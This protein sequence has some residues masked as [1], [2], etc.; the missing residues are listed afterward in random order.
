MEDMK[1]GNVLIRKKLYYDDDDDIKGNE[2]RL[3]DKLSCFVF[4]YMLTVILGSAGMC[5]NHSF[6]PLSEASGI[7]SSL[8]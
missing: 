8:C 1:V 4:S 3:D 2:I 6:L 7:H 5:I